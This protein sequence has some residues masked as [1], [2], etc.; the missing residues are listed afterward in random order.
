LTLVPEDLARSL[1]S[2]SVSLSTPWTVIDFIRPPM[3][4]TTIHIDSYYESF[5]FFMQVRAGDDWDPDLWR[6][7]SVFALTPAGF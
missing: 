6:F 1:M 7:S 2:F 5:L 3:N 4:H